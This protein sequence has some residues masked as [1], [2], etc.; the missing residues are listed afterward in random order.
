MSQAV[1]TKKDFV[2]DQTIRWCPGCG[3]Y[4]ILTAVQKTLPELG[5]AR[6]NIAFVSGIGCSSRF[7]YYMNTYGF[8][9][10]HGRAPAIASG[11]KLMR[12]ELSVWIATGDGDA[13]SIGGNH[14]I[15]LLR[16]NLDINLILFNNEIYGLTKGQY[17]PTSARGTIAKSTPDGSIDT[18]FSPVKLASG[19]GASFIARTFDKDMKHMEKI[20]KRAYDHKGTSF[21]EVLQN[22]VIFNDG[23]H[24]PVTNREVRADTMIMVEHGQK[25]LFGKENEKGLKL[26]HG[27]FEIVSALDNPNQIAVFDENDMNFLNLFETHAGHGGIP[28]PAGVLYRNDRSV[29]EQE[30]LQQIQQVTA[31]KGRGEIRKLLHAGETWEVLGD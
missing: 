1:L 28:V 10:I 31:K 11:L 19:A 20:V 9:T 8:H 29:Y 26:G 24:D 27:S 4:G 23:V 21:I 2:S 3:D 16:R 13:L 25:L 14:F 7:P 30:V 22:C 15:H 6:E 12:P 5:V 18:P 17:S